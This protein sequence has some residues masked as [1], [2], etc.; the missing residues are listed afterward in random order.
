MIVGI[1]V[2]ILK[3][4]RMKLE[5]AKRVLSEEEFIIFNEFKLESRKLEYLAGRFA[6]KEAII[7]AIGNTKYI[8]GMRDIAILNDDNGLPYVKKP[9]YD[10][11]RIMI[12]LSHEKD[13]S[14]GMCVI[15]NV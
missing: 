3:I 13:N 6:A 15:E 7:K 11:I 10:D 9:V 5:H 12:S 14:I 2:D 8:V 4:S 1:G